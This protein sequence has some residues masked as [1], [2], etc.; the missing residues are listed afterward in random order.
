MNK[1]LRLNPTLFYNDWS[2]IQFNALAPG[3]VIITQNAGDAVIKGGEFEMQFAATDRW[4][5]DASV[6]YLDGH[7]TRID[8]SVAFI[9]AYPN[10]SFNPPPFPGP[11]VQLV[12]LA[13]DDDMQQSPKSKYTAGAR[14][15]HP[16]GSGGRIVAGV[17]YAHVDTI[18]S[19]VTRSNTVQMPS[20]SLLS[21][22]VQ[23]VGRDDRWSVALFGT[24]LTDEYY[25]IGGVNFG[26]LGPGSIEADIA[27]P[28]EFGVTVHFNF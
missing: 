23:F 9:T 12:D 18:R 7:Y 2:D 27:R 20:Y 5:L 21:A 1:R 11:S 15:S 4:L 14:Y 6:S 26:T 28:R 13:L 22:Q 3:A 16:L 19:A 8:P 24:N 25:Y 17:N 10:G